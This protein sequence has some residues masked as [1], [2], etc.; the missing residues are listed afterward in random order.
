[1]TY[2]V[3]ASVTGSSSPPAWGDHV[4]RLLVGD[5]VDPRPAAFAPSGFEMGAEPAVGFGAARILG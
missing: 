4:A 5:G 3:G 2:E 1:M